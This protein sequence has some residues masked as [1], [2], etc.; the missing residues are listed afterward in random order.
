MCG[1]VA[2]LAKDGRRVDAEELVRIRDAI[3]RRGPDGAGL[4]ISDDFRVGLGHR[5]LAIIDLSRSAQQPMSTLDGRLRIVFNGEIYNYRALRARLIERG[6]RFRTSS[7]T[8]VLLHL[9]DD[10]GAEMVDEL[11]GMYAFAL[12]DAGR[13]LLLARDPFGI[14]PLYYSDAGGF[15][16]VASQVKGPPSR[17][18]CVSCARTGRARGLPLVG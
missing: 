15:F 6:Y 1:I 2:I 9:Y 14:K 11:R 7:D 13:G 12:W 10:R 17:V 16:R 18:R 3:R 8:E 4:W 5:R